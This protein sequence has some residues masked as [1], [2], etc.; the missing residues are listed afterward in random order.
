MSQPKRALRMLT[1]SVQD[2]YRNHRADLETC[3]HCRHV[4]VGRMAWY[5]YAVTLVL[6]PRNHKRGSVAI[7]SECPKCFGISWIHVEMDSFA[8]MVP[9]AP[10]KWIATVQALC[11]STRL[12]ALRDWGAGKCHRCAH[13]ESGTVGYSAWRQ[14]PI[15]SGPAVI[16][17]EK[18]TEFHGK[19]SPSV[20]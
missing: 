2:N 13:L 12:Q 3:P 11:A 19:K 6:K 8:Y 17:C 18:F 15:G 10:A 20:P 5:G 9:A 16:T 14:C 1:T 4:P 7:V